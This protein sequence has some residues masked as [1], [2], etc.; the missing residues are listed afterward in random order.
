MRNCDWASLK[1]RASRFRT[2]FLTVVGLILTGVGLVYTDG[3][4]ILTGVRFLRR[5]GAGIKVAQKA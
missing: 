2:Q 3:G 5:M 4:L 1:K